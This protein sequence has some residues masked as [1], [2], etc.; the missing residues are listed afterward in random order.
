[1]ADKNNTKALSQIFGTINVS[2][3]S[4]V[5]N[6]PGVG[7]CKSLTCLILFLFNIYKIY[8]TLC[9]LVLK[10]PVLPDMHDNFVLHY[11]CIHMK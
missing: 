2:V 10:L 9:T 6:G 5:C 8:F 3:S 4:Y 11:T 1:M 7:L